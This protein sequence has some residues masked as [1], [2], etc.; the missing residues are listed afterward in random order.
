MHQ[1]S[2][3]PASMLSFVS[4]Y[5]MQL[6]NEIKSVRWQPV[7]KCETHVYRMRSSENA[8]D[9]QERSQ[10]GMLSTNEAYEII[11]LTILRRHETLKWS[12]IMEIM[13]LFFIELTI[14]IHFFNVS[15]Q[16]IWWQSKVSFWA[17]PTYRLKQMIAKSINNNCNTV[18][19]KM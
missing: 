14:N 6:S 18:S 13:W 15:C 11:K 7:I 4:N 8:A 3:H 12:K 2:L 10:M 9:T 17:N 19:A 1:P 5:R 16:R